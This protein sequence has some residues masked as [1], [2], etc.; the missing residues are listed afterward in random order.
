MAP[1]VLPY[2]SW[3]AETQRYFYWATGIL[4]DIEAGRSDSP[5]LQGGSTPVGLRY[6]VRQPSDLDALLAQ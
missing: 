3:A 5:R 1:L 6:V 4:E 2:N